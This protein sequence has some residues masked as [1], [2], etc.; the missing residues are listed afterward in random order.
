MWSDNMEE[1]RKKGGGMLVYACMAMVMFLFMVWYSGM[2]EFW[3]DEVYQLGMVRDSLDVKGMLREYAQLKD[4]TPP[5]YALICYF[6]VRIVP[7]SF[8][9]LLLISEGFAA[10]GVFVTSLVGERVGGKKLGLLTGIF[11]AT[12][13][14]LVLSA[15]YEFRSYSLYFTASAF[16]FL[17]LAKRIQ[18]PGRTVSVQY[19]LALVL[20]L[21]SHYYGTVLFAVLF[22]LEVMFAARRHIKWSRLVVY[23]VSG[24]AFLPWMLLVFVY[25]TRSMTEFWIQPPDLMSVIELFRYLCSENPFVLA[26]L[27]LGTA[28]TAV[29]LADRCRRRAFACEKDGMWVYLLGTVVGVVVVMY[30]YG[31][32]I[33]PDG[34]LFYKRYFLGLLPCCFVILGAGTAWLVDL[35][36]AGRHNRTRIFYVIALALALVL[37]AQNGEY[38]FG[39]LEKKPALSYT[40]AVGAMSRCEDITSPDVAVVTTDN[41]WV[42]AGIEMYFDRLFHTKPVVLSQHDEAF[43]GHVREYRKLYVF[44]GKQPMTEQTERALGGYKRIRKIAG[45][46]VTVYERESEPNENTIK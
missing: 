39:K 32:Y 31:A 22:L 16:V 27:G 17:L 8:R 13:S 36:A 42:R 29:S 40:G 37:S 6:W 10:L 4:Y 45:K 1:G 44:K 34:G 28:L 35:P 5:L 19:G 41:P 23:V 15:G 25:R 11:A 21:Y 3:Y 18:N 12:S 14:V 43:A 33:N 2:Q 9:W 38:L 26:L 30:V 7:F 46:R 24:A 20:L